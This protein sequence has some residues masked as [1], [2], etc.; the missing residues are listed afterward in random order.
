M[1]KIETKLR[2]LYTGKIKTRNFGANTKF[3]FQ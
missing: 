3:E 1:I 2:H